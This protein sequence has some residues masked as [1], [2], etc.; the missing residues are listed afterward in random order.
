MP[1]GQGG[2]LKEDGGQRVGLLLED[3]GSAQPRAP[4]HKSVRSSDR[5]AEQVDLAIQGPGRPLIQKELIHHHERR[6]GAV[7]F[8]D[9][10]EEL[11]FL[12]QAGDPDID[13]EAVRPQ[14]IVKHPQVAEA[15]TPLGGRQRR[16]KPVVQGVQFGR[17]GGAVV[18]HP[19]GIPRGGDRMGMVGACRQRPRFAVVRPARAFKRVVPHALA[20][21]IQHASAR[22]QGK[23]RRF[24]A[25]LPWV[26]VSRASKT[27]TIQRSSSKCPHASG[28][29]RTVSMACC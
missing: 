29:S 18:E 16:P 26:K 21:C 24:H 11:F 15:H 9:S 4:F 25:V 14:P 3:P 5:G 28:A 17:C 2:R 10:A 20:P 8:F 19:T 27:G 23:Q 1:C 22:D 12:Q 6:I 13:M 7:D